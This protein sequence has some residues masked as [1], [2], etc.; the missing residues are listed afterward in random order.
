M[1]CFYWRE[2][3]LEVDFVL[4]R[5]GMVA[6][7]EVKSGRCKDSLPGMDAFARAFNPQ[8]KL[9]VGSQGI[10]IDEF[11]SVPVETWLSE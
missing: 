11:L 4:R 5:G 2:G 6:A 9:L 1:E 10:P 3:S 7:L 8:R